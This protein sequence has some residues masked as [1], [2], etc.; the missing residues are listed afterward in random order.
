MTFDAENAET[1]A[2]LRAFT[3]K[4]SF[5]GEESWGQHAAFEVD[6]FQTYDAPDF[7]EYL[8]LKFGHLAP[9]AEEE[10]CVSATETDARS[11]EKR[12]SSETAPTSTE[13]SAP[14]PD[15]AKVKNGRGVGG[16]AN[17]NGKLAVNV[18]RGSV[19]SDKSSKVKGKLKGVFGFGSKK[20]R[21]GSGFCSS[22]RTKALLGKPNSVVSGNR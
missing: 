16:C 20:K 12:S 5:G 18:D 22:D 1:Y 17:G 2:L 7:K 10:S 8:G 15:C 4:Y 9:Q 3:K 6:T 13:I 19:R 14:A 21:M 11:S